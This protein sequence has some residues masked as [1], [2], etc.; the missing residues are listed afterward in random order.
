MGPCPN[1]LENCCCRRI[2]HK[3]DN[4]PTHDEGD[5]TSPE[6]IFKN[7][8]GVLMIRQIFLE[9]NLF[10]VDGALRRLEALAEL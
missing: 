9:V 1:L 5:H 4:P 8:N 10:E 3:E 7:R 2:Q 6:H